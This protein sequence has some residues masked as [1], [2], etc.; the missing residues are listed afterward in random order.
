MG[1]FGCLAKEA[2]APPEGKSYKEWTHDNIMWWA[3]RELVPKSVRKKLKKKKVTGQTIT[4]IGSQ[5]LN[6]VPEAAREIF[7]LKRDELVVN[8]ARSRNQTNDYND[9]T[10][11]NQ[12]GTVQLS[13]MTYDKREERILE[14]ETILKAAT[15]SVVELSN[16]NPSDRTEFIE[17]SRVLVRLSQPKNPQHESDRSAA[18]QREKQLL[19]SELNAVSPTPGCPKPPLASG[20]VHPNVHNLPATPLAEK[21]SAKKP[22]ATSK[23]GGHD[24]IELSPPISPRNTD[25]ARTRMIVTSCS[26]SAKSVASSQ[27]FRDNATSN[28]SSS[29]VDEFKSPILNSPPIARSGKSTKITQVL[30][31]EEEVSE[32][33]LTNVAPVHVAPVHVAPVHVDTLTSSSVT[34]VKVKTPS[35]KKKL[36]P[37]ATSPKTPLG[38]NKKSPKTFTSPSPGRNVFLSELSALKRNR[39]PQRTQPE[40]IRVRGAVVILGVDFTGYQSLENSR[41]LMF[42]SAVREDVCKNLIGYSVP[43]SDVIGVEVH[44][45][46]N[47]IVFDIAVDEMREWGVAAELRRLLRNGTFSVEAIKRACCF[48]FGMSESDMRV[49]DIATLDARKVRMRRSSSTNNIITSYSQA[50]VSRQRSVDRP[51]A[52]VAQVQRNVDISK[53]EPVYSTHHEAILQRLHRTANQIES[54]DTGVS[55]DIDRLLS[56]L[57]SA[58]ARHNLNGTSVLSE[59]NVNH[60]QSKKG[61][62][63]S[64]HRYNSPPPPP[65]IPSQSHNITGGDRSSVFNHSNQSG[66]ESPVPGT[67]GS[68]ATSQRLRFAGKSQ[69]QSDSFG[70]R[71]VTPVQRSLF[72]KNTTVYQAPLPY[73]PPEVRHERYV[74]DNSVLAGGVRFV[75]VDRIPDRSFDKSIDFN[76]SVDTIADHQRVSPRPPHPSNPISGT[77]PSSYSSGLS[78]HQQNQLNRADHIITGLNSSLGIQQSRPYDDKITRLRSLV[79]DEVHNRHF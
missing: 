70:Y 55:Q 39:V 58:E 10:I 73:T 78:Q 72:G 2:E 52:S 77:F 8:D 17:K 27:N 38:F 56:E 69:D 31:P 4:E 13:E 7:Y 23:H 9:E 51:P 35:K 11:W 79:R 42:E 36:S 19:L 12:V 18:I 41:R 5:E 34:P 24:V 71:S 45:K 26:S 50:S 62:N 65:P 76:L 68:P 1:F 57:H 64:V 61:I 59:R 75:D 40:S 47:K 29:Y 74:N 20:R 54:H 6:T 16:L 37:A 63:K 25:V 15:N 14:N 49:D 22:A 46:N 30:S 43:P 32:P 3:K 48:H 21:T 44:P 60:S 67:Q 33:R 66:Y 28:S 53:S